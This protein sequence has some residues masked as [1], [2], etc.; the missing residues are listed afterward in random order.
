MTRHRVQ[1]APRAPLTSNDVYG[2]RY[3]NH[4]ARTCS[5]IIPKDPNKALK[6][7][8]SR[9]TANNV[10][11]ELQEY[12]QYSDPLQC[13]DKDMDYMIFNSMHSQVQNGWALVPNTKKDRL[14]I[15][16]YGKPEPFTVKECKTVRKFW[17][18]TCNQC[19]RFGCSWHPWTCNGD[20]PD[21]DCCM[22]KKPAIAKCRR[23]HIHQGYRME[24]NRLE[25]KIL[26]V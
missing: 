7:K 2:A 17:K 16:R 6:W 20:T 1:R 10:I 25:S 15:Q 24:T 4:A 13:T 26:H 19:N 18:Y 12:L 9:M 21:D 5:T 8:S 14:Y 11:S 3:W 23:V 22:K